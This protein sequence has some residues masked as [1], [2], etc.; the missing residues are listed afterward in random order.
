MANR[1]LAKGHRRHVLSTSDKGD[2]PWLGRG[3]IS[4]GESREAQGS[5]EGCAMGEAH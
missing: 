3:C 4:S 2:G 5:M 1:C